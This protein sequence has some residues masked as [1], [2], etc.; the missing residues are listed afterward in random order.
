MHG[1]TRKFLEI[2]DDT[3]NPE[4][5]SSGSLF[6]LISFITPSL[7]LTCIGLEVFIWATCGSTPAIGTIVSAG[8][9]YSFWKVYRAIAQLSKGMGVGQDDKSTANNGHDQKGDINV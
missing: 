2:K 9:L 5:I 3:T 7:A 4:A 1:S 8:I 6:W